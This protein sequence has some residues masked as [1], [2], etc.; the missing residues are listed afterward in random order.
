MRL[1]LNFLGDIQ[2]SISFESALHGE[3]KF[4][5]QI[6]DFNTHKLLSKEIHVFSKI[7]SY[8]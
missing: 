7:D 3:T 8:D 1:L 5:G 6:I 4:A 2:C